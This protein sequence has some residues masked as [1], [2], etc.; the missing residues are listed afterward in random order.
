MFVAMQCHTQ[1]TRW[2]NVSKPTHQTPC[3][4]EKKEENIS[5]GP[6]VPHENLVRTVVG[7]EVLG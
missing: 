1:W 7:D 6:G 5:V 4:E 2:R 3:K